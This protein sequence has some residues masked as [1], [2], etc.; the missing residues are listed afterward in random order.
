[1]IKKFYSII[2]DKVLSAPSE[3]GEPSAGLLQA[4]VRDSALSLLEAKAARV[5]EIGC[6]EG[7]FLKKVLQRWPD[8]QCTGVDISGEQLERAR[9]RL[10]S[11]V[12]LSQVNGGELPFS[13]A[14]FD[15]VAAVN[16]LMNLPDDETVNAVLKEAARVCRPGAEL[17]C[18]IRN[19]GNALMRL[20]YRTAGCYD[21]TIDC[22]R[23]KLYTPDDMTQRLE[24][25][26]FIIQTL[27][28]VRV[29]PL[30]VAAYLIHAKRS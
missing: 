19:G 14:F 5:L 16:L 18:D 2:R 10:G 9:G 29:F 17:V 4:R 6:G 8:A 15:K 26:G 11:A 12:T 1:M 3:A 25:A 28:P 20:K 21:A 27:R 7:F 13:D 24:A 22:S 30:G 23:L